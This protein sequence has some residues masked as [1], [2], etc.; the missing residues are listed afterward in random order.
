MVEDDSTYIFTEDVSK[1]A[2]PSTPVTKATLRICNMSTPITKPSAKQQRKIKPLPDPI[3]EMTSAD[4]YRLIISEELDPHSKSKTYGKLMRVVSRVKVI[5]QNNDDIVLDHL[6]TDQ[7]HLFARNI[8]VPNLGSK[9]KF[10]C[11]LAMASH[12]EFQHQLSSFGLSPTAQANQT[13]ANVC[14]AVNVIF[15]DQFIEDLKKVNDRK[16]QTDHESGNTHKHFWVWAAM[17]YNNRQDDDV[18]DDRSMEHTAVA[19]PEDNES[20]ME[21]EFATLI[22]SYKDPVLAHLD[23]NEEVDLA[24]FEQMETNA[25]QKKCLDLFKVSSIMKE[26]MT[27][28]GTHDS[29]PYN[30][31]E[32][33]MRGFTGLTPISVFYFYKRCDE[34]PDID[35]VFQPFMNDDLKGNSITLGTC[36]DDNT[37]PSTLV[38][39]SKTVLFDQM[40]MM[41]QQGSQLLELLK[42]SIEEQKLE[43]LDRKQ[44]QMDCDKR[45]TIN[46]QIEIAKALGDCEEL[47]C[48]SNELK[49]SLK[50]H[51]M[52]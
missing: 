52:T 27:K 6:T 22:V 30:F 1:T 9:N 31:V 49:E 14:R 44:E 36:D 37:S 25:F 3:V 26:N 46:S 8:G 18:V 23:T 5:E 51:N 45:S 50:E 17:A 48:L 12:F 32:V 11:H 15:S 38:S 20:T 33:A 34:H 43:Q 4:S 21:D 35:S 7:V 29:D 40:D 16:S 47:Q 42:M 19:I 41:V 10:V 24:Q 28:S 39:T 13:T 2:K